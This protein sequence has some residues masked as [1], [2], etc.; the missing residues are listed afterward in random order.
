MS[1]LHPD[2]A[3]SA[4]A[5]ARIAAVVGVMSRAA[6]EHAPVVLASSFGAEDMVLIDLLA[7]HAL[8][9]G[10]LTLDTGRLPDETHA[11]IDRVRATYRI[12]VD[13][14]FPEAAAV[15]PFVRANGVNAFYTSPAL[16]EQCCAIRKTQPLARALAGKGAWITGLRRE[17]SPTRRDVAIEAFDATYG[18]VKLNPLADWTRDDVWS[19]L[20]ER[21]VP[22]NALHERG[23]ASIGCAPCTR[24]IEPGEDERAGR[25]WWESADRKECG[26]HRRPGTIPITP[27]TIVQ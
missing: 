27:F 4:A 26:L 21:R 5:E 15:E 1:T 3:S 12:A 7:T 6:S 8:S 11:L 13:V 9:I 24:A 22:Y 18:L 19:Y 10:V 16:R 23:Y 17:Q 25:W 2:R 14:H 20:H